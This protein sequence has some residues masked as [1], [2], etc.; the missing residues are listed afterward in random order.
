MAE[1]LNQLV[2]Q[3]KTLSA[4]FGARAAQVKKSLSSNRERY[5]GLIKTYEHLIDGDDET[6]SRLPDDR[7]EIG[8]SVLQELAFLADFFNQAC[9]AAVRKEASNCEAKADLSIGSSTWTG[10]PVSALLNLEHKLGT[11]KAVLMQVPTL[12]DSKN[13]VPE[14]A[15]EG[16]FR[17]VPDPWSY[18]TDKRPYS[19]EKSPATDKHKAQSE[20]LYEDVKVGKWSTRVLCGAVPM[21]VKIKMLKNVDAAIAAV[22]AAREKANLAEAVPS[23]PFI[24]LF[25]FLIS[26]I[27]ESLEKKEA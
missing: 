19:F 14:S 17:Q 27:T 12:E 22:V 26:P 5:T 25:A 2:R 21:D 11:M 1:T 6:K 10:V 7:K 15:E 24:E 4:D 20:I 23:R 18:R 16:I 9:S 3:E 13:W 8:T